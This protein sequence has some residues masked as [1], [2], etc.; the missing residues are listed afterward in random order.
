[1]I[2]EFPQKK[3]GDKRLTRIVCLEA[4]FPD[5]ATTGLANGSEL[6]VL[7]TAN[8]PKLYDEENDS[9]YDTTG[10]AYTGGGE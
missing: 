2:R 1:M 7:D 6:V 5:V 8:N 4:D 10:T 9:W 3:I